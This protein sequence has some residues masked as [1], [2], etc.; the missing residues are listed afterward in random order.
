MRSN[1]SKSEIKAPGCHS[2]ALE[3]NGPTPAAKAWLDTVIVPALVRE[4]LKTR[5]ATS[6]VL[7]GTSKDV[8]AFTIVDKELEDKP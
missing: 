3:P 6:L 4:F 5:K 2:R 8:V 7:S 1:L